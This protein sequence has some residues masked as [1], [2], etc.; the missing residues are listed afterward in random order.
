MRREISKEKN[1]AIFRGNVYIL[2]PLTISIFFIYCGADS[3]KNPLPGRGGYGLDSFRRSVAEGPSAISANLSNNSSFV[4]ASER[5][6]RRD[7]L[8]DFKYYT[9]GWNISNR[10]YWASVGFT[11]APLFVIAVA[12]FVIFGLV[13][14]FT[15]CY[16][17]CCRRTINSYSRAAYAI[18]L[19]LLVL[20]TLA[21]I[22]GCVLLYNGQGKFHNSTSD[23]LDYVVGQ[24][25]LTV[26]NLRDFSA[27]L[28]AAKR[29]QVTNL[30]V[31]GDLQGRIDAIV[32]KVNTSANDLNRR[33]SKNSKNIK[34]VLDTVRLVLIVVAAVMLLLAFLGFLFSILGL[35]FLVYL[36]VLIGWFLVAGTFIMAGV[37]LLLHNSVGDT[38]VAMEEWVVHPSEHTALD[39]IL[40]CVDVATA[41]QSLYSSREVTYKLADIVNN[42][43]N[44]VANPSNPSLRYNQSGP[45]M[46]TLCNPFN[47][48]LSIRS[49]APGEVAFINASKVWS[50]YECNATT[51]NGF[52]I[53]TS[54]GRVTPAIYVQ[55]DAAVS[56]G[57]ALYHYG[58]FL[59]QL[60]DCSFVR[61][62]FSS[63]NQNN[64]PGLR[65]YTKWVYVGL[66]IVSAAVMLSTI[67]WVVYARERRHRVYGKRHDFQERHVQM[68]D[69]P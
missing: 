4:L 68:P 40:P 27:N 26:E 65:K 24:A 14:L 17:C 49:C 1:M 21:A 37:F 53:C 61:K 60:E 63:I 16:Y 50:K 34:D 31:P 46:P 64:C 51:V 10:H 35:Q 33:T 36:L 23:T 38:C 29:I 44:G 18:S 15:A 56:I 8:N 25:N 22:V 43:I 58:P 41:N 42:V 13:L 19:T 39:D 48:D 45:S 7:P 9:G 57:Y 69:K 20:F 55:M 12:W 59:V 5:T 47:Q 3:P 52:E 32:T 30:L 6:D 11:G 54:V 62:T 2:L 67:F 66:T 28:S